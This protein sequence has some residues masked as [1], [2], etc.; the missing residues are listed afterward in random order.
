MDPFSIDSDQLAENRD[1]F[2]AFDEG[3]SSAGQFDVLGS[4][5]EQAASSQLP[6][7]PDNND[8]MN[9]ARTGAT[10]D[11]F[12]DDQPADSANEVVDK[13]TTRFTNQDDSAA[14]SA[15]GSELPPSILD[16]LH[17][18]LA[19]PAPSPPTLSNASINSLSLSW[20]PVEEASGYF[21]DYEFRSGVD[22]DPEGVLLSGTGGRVVNGGMALLPATAQPRCRITGL[23]KNAC[24]VVTVTAVRRRRV[25]LPDGQALEQIVDSPPSPAGGPF[26]TL[27]AGAEI[28]RLQA[29]NNRLTRENDRIPELEEESEALSAQLS[30]TSH[31]LS[32]ALGEVARLTAELAE[33]TDEC[34]AA[35]AR[36]GSLG[37]EL[38]SANAVVRVN[39]AD[40][41]G[42]NAVIFWRITTSP[43][44]L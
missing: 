35:Q 14:P 31:Q 32:D 29:E 22:G 17:P 11:A 9:T 2:A 10:F 19:L 23:H 13:V 33:R 27:A 43:V 40:T 16:G 12:T 41:Y 28:A 5:S 21:V 15:L 7:S 6:P 24:Y 3:S 39:A 8:A 44:T 26:R 37:G 36:I 25:V 42:F 18:L 1:I 30:E 4:P 20:T 34:D 38:E